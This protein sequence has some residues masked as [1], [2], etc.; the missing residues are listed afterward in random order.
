LNTVDPAELVAALVWQPTERSRFAFIT[1]AVAAQNRVDDSRADLMTTD[2]YVVVDL[3]A[4][5]RI[6]ER[7]RIDAGLFN[8]FDKEYWHWSSIRNRSTNDP[9]NNYLSAPG[10]YASVSIRMDLER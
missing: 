3:T 8:A 2:G 6:T 10:R 5:F 9:M 1:T 4:S 7:A